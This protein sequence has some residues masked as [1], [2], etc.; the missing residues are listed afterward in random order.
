MYHSFLTHSFTDGLLGSFQHLALIN[1]V[2]MNIGVHRFFWIGDLEFLGYSS[3]NGIAGLKAIPSLVFWGNSILFSTVA[4]PV[5]SPTSSALGF[6]FLRILSN[7]CCLLICLWWPFWLM[8]SGIS[9]WF[10][11]ASLW[12]LVML[13]ILS[14]LWALCM[15]SLEKSL[16]RACAHFLIGLFVFLEWSCMSYLYIL[17]IRPFSEESLVNTFSHSICS[18]FILMLFSL[19]MQ[20][21]F[22]LMQSHLFILYFMSLALGDVSVRML[23]CGMSEIFLPMFWRR[24]LKQDV[25]IIEFP[26]INYKSVACYS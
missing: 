1:S 10:Q 7:I 24:N 21:L 23:L 6:P 17:E 12:W 2:A 14:C 13:S 25:K 3:S 11:F 20:K 4:A 15:S 16:F 8:W 9:L 19:A 18:L 5:C 26:L 22:I